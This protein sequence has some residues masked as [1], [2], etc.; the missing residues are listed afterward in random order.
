MNIN[1]DKEKKRKMYKKD[2]NLCKTRKRNNMA[3]ILFPL[4]ILKKTFEKLSNMY[5]SLSIV[6]LK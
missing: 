6:F 1:K 4:N 5:I 3:R 2:R